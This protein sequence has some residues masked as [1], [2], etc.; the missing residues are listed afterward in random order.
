MIKS[1]E[2]RKWQ[3]NLRRY[4][5]DRHPCVGYAPYFGLDIENMRR[6]FECQFEKG[7][8][9]EHFAK[10]WQ[11]DHIISVTYFDFTSQ[12]ELKLC[13]NFT[14]I[15]VEPLQRGNNGGNRLDLLAAKKYFKELYDKTQYTPCLK[16]LNK[17]EEIAGT[18]LVSTEKQESFIREHR[19]FLNTIENYSPFEFELLNAG[20]TV[21]EVKKES[22][23]LKNIKD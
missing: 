7:L 8:G 2:K 5:L 3:I 18:E 6:W 16:L 9:W 17:I 22:D 23:F 19:S 1:R 12:E 21:E 15:R 11:F 10:E 13:W 4:V 20:R 14:N